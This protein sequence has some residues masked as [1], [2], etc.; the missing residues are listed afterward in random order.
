MRPEISIPIEEAFQII[1]VECGHC[2]TK[3]IFDL[4]TP[5]KETGLN[6][7]REHWSEES[8]CP[9]CNVQFGRSFLELITELED[10]RK[11]KIHAHEASVPLSVRIRIPFSG[12]EA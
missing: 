5:L 7:A 3:S 9:R 12:R 2:K 1:E 8:S 4:S 11:R 10:I 6:R